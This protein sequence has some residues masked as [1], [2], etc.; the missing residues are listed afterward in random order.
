[1]PSN[2]SA[3]L[4]ALS[5][6]LLLGQIGC[7]HGSEPL[8][9]GEKPRPAIIMP[10]EGELRFLR[11]GAAPLLLK[12]DPKTTG[13]RR[14]VLGRSDLPP[15]DSIG[16]HRHLREDEIILITRGTARVRLGT[17]QYTA[18]PG[19]AVFI[20]QGSCIAVA[21][22][23]GDTLTNFFIFSA[24]GFEEVLRAVSSKAGA[25][26]KTVTPAERAAAF[27]HGHAEASPADC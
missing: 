15:G 3:A 24:P 6:A 25:P 23:G 11:G 9:S 4:L 2:R 20:P 12:I 17:T 26:P 1:M 18:G 8:Q 7:G 10:D 14:L 21:N 13:S 5:S 22:A 19:A 16:V 27:R